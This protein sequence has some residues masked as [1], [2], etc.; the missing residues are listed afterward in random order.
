MISLK[1][2]CDEF[3]EYGKRIGYFSI[4]QGKEFREKIMSFRSIEDYNIDGDAV[5]NT[6]NKTI[7]CNPLR[8]KDEKNLSLVLFHE[9]THICSDIHKEMY[10]SDGLWK[11]M[12]DN[13]E[14]FTGDKRKSFKD[15]NGNIIDYSNKDNPYNYIMFGALLMD[16]V[17]AEKVATEIV[18]EKYHIPISETTKVFNCGNNNSIRYRS[19]FDYYGIGENLLDKFAKTLFI[20]GNKNLN[21]L[22]RESFK[23]DFVFNL[24]RQHNENS[25]TKKDF[26]DEIALMGV[27]AHTV[28]KQYGRYSEQEPIS[29][30]IVYD[31]IFQ[32]DSILR[33]G[34]EERNSIPQSIKFPDLF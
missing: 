18:K 10:L 28:E 12:R 23:K 11:K 29:G 32:L 8:I 33:S 17:I 19:S 34:Y 13:I 9:F 4:D 20:Q 21:T 7:K 24:I 25:V 6:D 30:D 31:S 1:K 16:E 14:V 26:I 27:I 15:I 22:A 5:V 2:Y 3:I